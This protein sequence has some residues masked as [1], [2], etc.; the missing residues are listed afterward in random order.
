MSEACVSCGDA[1]E[2]VLRDV[3]DT[4]FGAPGAWNI[5][6]CVACGLEHT[7]P[8]PTGPELSHLYETYYNYGGER[9]TAY[10]DR[11][12]QFLMS[13]LY[14]AW[15]KLDGDISFHGERGRGRLL[16]VGCNEGRGLVL[17]RRNGFHAEGLELNPR[18]A[19]TARR[20]GFMVYESDIEQ[21]TTSLPFERLVMSNVLEHALDPRAMLKAAHRL[22]A[23][24]GEIW[25]SLPNRESWLR[26]VFGRAWVN[27]H[28]P[29]HIV[30]FDRLTLAKLLR[31]AGFQVI[32]V[33]NVTPALWAAQSA[34]VAAFP[35]KPKM[36]RSAPVV[37]A[38]TL[39]SRFVLF[40][41]LWLGNRADRGDCLVVKARRA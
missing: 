34:I 33:E 23:P 13:G 32:A 7:T 24:G 15:L 26:R 25:I 37:A 41:L 21:L 2:I 36:L 11:R 19:E 5:A 16:D 14:Q 12:E 22:L 31:E 38:L 18:A 10:T 8:R 6:R 1:L 9:D 29:F 39:L 3:R 35:G 40:P 30:H 27:W 4:R 20:R 28:A 17:Y